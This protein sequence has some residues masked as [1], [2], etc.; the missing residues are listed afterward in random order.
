MIPCKVGDLVMAKVFRPYN[1]HEATIHGEVIAVS[2]QMFR[3]KY[4]FCRYMDFTMDDIGNTVF[5]KDLNGD[6]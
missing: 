2:G 4:M 6:G 5:I 1:G 3:V